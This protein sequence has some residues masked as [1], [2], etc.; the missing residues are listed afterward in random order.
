MFLWEFVWNDLKMVCNLQSLVYDTQFYFCNH[1]VR[2]CMFD[3]VC[4]T[5]K[6]RVSKWTNHRLSVDSNKHEAK[7]GPSRSEKAA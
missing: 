1:I 7:E 6:Y 2:M 4:K 5:A 3:K